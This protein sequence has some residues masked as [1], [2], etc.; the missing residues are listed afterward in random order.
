MLADIGHPYIVEAGLLQFELVA[1]PMHDIGLVDMREFQH[2]EQ[3]AMAEEIRVMRIG[4][5]EVG[6]CQLARRSEM[7]LRQREKFQPTGEMIG[8]IQ[9]DD[10]VRSCPTQCRAPGFGVTDIALHERSSDV[11]I[12]CFDQ[13]VPGMGGLASGQIDTE[14]PLDV[15]MFEPEQQLVAASEAG[16]ENHRMTV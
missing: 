16:I 7:P 12:A 11:R 1:I 14:D 3:Q 9:R 4:Q 8:A 15:K 13:L 2:P 10:M 6:Q 5:K